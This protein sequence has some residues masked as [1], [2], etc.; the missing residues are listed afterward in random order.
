MRKRLVRGT[1][2]DAVREVNANVAPGSRVYETIIRPAKATAASASRRGPK[3][4]PYFVVGAADTV[5]T[6]G[7]CGV[8]V[9][10]H[11]LVNTIGAININD[12]SDV[13]SIRGGECPGFVVSIGVRF[14]MMSGF[15]VQFSSVAKQRAQ[16]NARSFLPRYD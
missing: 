6:Y 12:Y 1:G 2:I 4:V 14:E 16:S 11:Y 8:G 9:A 5:A 15:A 13:L 10:Y 7:F 3:F